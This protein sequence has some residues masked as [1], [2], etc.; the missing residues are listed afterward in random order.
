MG[1]AA[2]WGSL[3]RV[4]LLAAVWGSSFLW[5]KLALRGFSP[6]EVALV[7]VALGAAV[8]L[9]IAGMRGARM[10]RG[11]RTWTHLTVAAF[12][13]NA[14]PY[15]LFAFGEQSVDSNIAG[16]INATTPLW[17]LLLAVLVGS[18]VRLSVGQVAGLFL[19]FA[20]VLVILAPWRSAGAFGAGAAVITV[21]A[22]C[23]AVSYLYIERYLSGR[24]LDPIAMCGTQLLAATGLLALVLPF[25]GDVSV[26][27]R[28]D[29]LAAVAVL[30]MIGTGI[31]IAL[32]FRLIV[33]DG[34]AVASSVTY[35]LP[36]VS[37]LLGAVVLGEPFGLRMT[38]GIA[39]VLAGIALSRRKPAAAP[40]VE[41][42]GDDPGTLPTPTATG[43]SAP[44]ARA[45]V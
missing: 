32:N 1:G 26:D 9:A 29:A 19:G 15:A 22:F 42:R 6:V 16:V 24:G 7:R 27:P 13:N 43:R 40:A 17:T 41:A 12:F 25:T 38:A 5:I 3:G 33:D 28:P 4:A 45:G 23:Y 2:R 34:A 39:V 20:G 37:A 8:L 10:P 44:R 14:L 30:G 11:L 36:P 18:G 31:A 35:L 21:A